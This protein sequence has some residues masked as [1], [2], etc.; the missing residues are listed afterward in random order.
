MKIWS[1][2]VRM[3]RIDFALPLFSLSSKSIA[4]HAH[5]FFKQK[6]LF[7][8][9]ACLAERLKGSELPRVEQHNP[10]PKLV[11]SEHLNRGS[12]I[13]LPLLP[14]RHKKSI[15]HFIASA[16]FHCS[17]AKERMISLLH[18][19]KLFFF[20]F[21]PYCYVI[22]KRRMTHKTTIPIRK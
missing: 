1:H 4:L 14:D 8:I 18:Y 6:Q 16:S 21:S 22:T 20:V 5:K 3:L 10:Q 12:A 13:C 9:K 11:A 17:Y 7:C 2:F 19:R 15:S